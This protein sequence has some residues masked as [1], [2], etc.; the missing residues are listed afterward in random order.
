MKLFTS[1]IRELFAQFKLKNKTVI[2]RMPSLIMPACGRQECELL[3]MN[4][5]MP[6]PR[7]SFVSI[8]SRIRMMQ[9]VKPVST[10][11]CIQKINEKTTCNS[12][13]TGKQ[14]LR[15]IQGA[16][17]W[18]FTTK[19]CIKKCWEFA[20]RF[21]RCSRNT[22]ARRF[23][24]KVEMTALRN[25]GMVRASGLCARKPYTVYLIAL[26]ILFCVCLANARQSS[27][28]EA[29][30]GVALSTDSIRP[31]QIGD[32]IPEALWHMPLQMVKAGQE[33]STAITLNDYRGK[34][35]ILDFWATWCTPCIAMIPKMDSL[36]KTFSKQVQFI[37]CSS[38]KEEQVLPFIAK[39]EQRLKQQFHIPLVN[40]KN[41][42]YRAFPHVYL[43]HYVWIYKGRV[44][45]ITAFREV[46][47]SN[48]ESVLNG[49]N[50]KLPLK[51]DEKR[52]KV[53][54]AKPLFIDGNGGTGDELQYISQLAKYTPGISGYHLKIDSVNGDKITL[55]NMP[56]YK[57]YAFAYGERYD[58]IGDNRVLLTVKESEPIMPGEGESFK[59]WRMKYAYCYELKVPP[60]LNSRFYRMMQ[61]DL[62]RL[63]P[64]YRARLKKKKMRC[65]AL[66]RTSNIDKLKA[67]P[68][69]GL[70]ST[71]LVYS[72]NNGPL[73]NLID[74]LNIFSLQMLPTPVIDETGYRDFVTLTLDCNLSKVDEL[75]R[76]LAK[77]DL[78]LK[79]VK[80]NIKVLEIS[81]SV[82]KQ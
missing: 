71:K 29:A 50:V 52:V 3:M 67:K 18:F 56:L 63:F 40:G 68:G 23:L 41:F 31:L 11:D 43:P 36:Q 13:V 54:Y 59:Q 6:D 81:D 2:A 69:E 14:G 4:A 34:L 62:A 28:L 49:K 26:K 21:I 79:E 65:L 77:Y 48:I 37:S 64:Q 10:T 72:I 5:L 44:R 39:L 24:R 80:R 60:A 27:S 20:Y 15:S 16:F 76:E 35:I 78:A 46:N 70:E 42:L 17:W 75:N 58:Y 74:D 22:D 12:R 47:Q 55:S 53:D 33:G 66:V 45:A 38:Q 30:H 61:A 1:Y 73:S 82:L 8:C 25:V 19:I 9:V 57:I 32:T 7:R 51:I